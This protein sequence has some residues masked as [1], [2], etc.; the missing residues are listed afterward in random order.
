MDTNILHELRAILATDD[1]YDTIARSIQKLIDI[2]SDTNNVRTAV[3]QSIAEP[4]EMASTELISIVTTAMNTAED[5]GLEAEVI[6][7]AMQAIYS[8]IDNDIDSIQC[9]FDDVL[10]NL[11]C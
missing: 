7:D 9:A 5:A 8:S 1:C 11:D 10:M 6:H 4:A 3:M 2:K